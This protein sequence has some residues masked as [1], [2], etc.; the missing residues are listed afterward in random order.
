MSSSD[1]NRFFR[2]VRIEVSPNPF[3]PTRL[4]I[5]GATGITGPT[6]PTGQTGATGEVG[7][8]GPTGPTGQSGPVGNTGATGV[9][10][11][12]G[13]DG[14]TGPIGPNGNTGP[15]GPT[16]ATGEIGEVG[17]TG[18]TGFTGPIG[19]IGATGATGEVGAVG[20]TGPIGATGP[21]G[22]T[23]PTGPIGATGEVGEIGAIG[24]TGPTGP[25]GN[26]GPTGVVGPTGPQGNTGPAG[27]TGPAGEVGPTGN[28]GPGVSPNNFAGYIPGP[29]PSPATG[30]P[31][32]IDNYATVLA[33]S[34]F[35]PSSGIFTVPTVPVGATGTIYY[36]NFAGTYRNTDAIAL[37]T[38]RIS[39]FNLSTATE[40]AA[41]T[42]GSGSGDT[43]GF[44]YEPD[45]NLTY[46]GPLTPGNQVVVRVSEFG[47]TTTATLRNL[48]FRGSL[49]DYQP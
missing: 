34:G 25:I 9:S 8:T 46:I 14:P 48:S 3:S 7:A 29:I 20:D 45:L 33:G 19:P 18:S 32:D 11:S 6:G 28:P 38:P 22:F 2:G 15:V 12:T 10:G 49:L 27:A 23:G 42:Y 26:T 39:F 31:E 35:D 21:I 41:S 44:V 36:L 43:G 47:T 13:E 24:D 5:G 1:T 16:G 30:A 40:I 17:P 4:N 37:A